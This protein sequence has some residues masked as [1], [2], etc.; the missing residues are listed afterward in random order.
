MIKQPAIY[1]LARKRNGTLY[2]GVTSD[3]TK[4]IWEHRNNFID[5]FT[6][7]YDVHLLVYFEV[8]DVMEDA[9]DEDFIT[10]ISC[11]YHY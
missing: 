2:T 8:Y 4:R 5:G 3:L 11:G 1:I 7:K 6:K 10:V 9:V